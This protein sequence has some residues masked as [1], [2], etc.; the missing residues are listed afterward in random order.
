EE[1]QTIRRRRRCLACE[2]RFTTFERAELDLPYIV[3]R[4]GSRTD[5]DRAKL[6]A[7]LSLALRKRP[8][9]TADVDAAVVRIEEALMTSGLREVPSSRVGELVMQELKKLDQVA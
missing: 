7:S 1:G 8:V 4:N 3:K 9:A 2:R 5:Y 6:R